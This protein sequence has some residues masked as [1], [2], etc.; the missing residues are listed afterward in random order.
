MVWCDT[1]VYRRDSRTQPGVLQTF[2]VVT[3]S[4]LIQYLWLCYDSFV[5][6][7]LSLVWYKWLNCEFATF[8]LVSWVR[9]GTWLYRFM[10]FAP[11]LILMWLALSLVSYKRLLWWHIFFYHRTQSDVIQTIIGNVLMHLWSLSHRKSASTNKPVAF[12]SVHTGIEP[13]F[14][15]KIYYA[16]TACVTRSFTSRK[17][18]LK[19][20][21]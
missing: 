12:R 16:I 21:W 18:W 6:A 11:L 4:C 14:L 5:I 20:K 1:N 3:C 17:Y 19:E 13:P 7:I 8:P 2:I 10:I 9:C 15:L